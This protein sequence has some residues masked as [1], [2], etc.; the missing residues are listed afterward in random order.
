MYLINVIMADM[1]YVFEYFGLM[2]HHTIQFAFVFIPTVLLHRARKI[3]FG[4]Q[5]KDLKKGTKYL[6]YICAF[7]LLVSLMQALKGAHMIPSTDYIIFQLCFSG[8]GEEI[9]YR[10]IPIALLC[11]ASA[12]ETRIHLYGKINIDYSVLISALF[13]SIAHISFQFGSTNITYSWVQLLYSFSVGLILGHAY[14]KVN[15][16]WYCMFLHGLC[17]VVAIIFPL[18]FSVI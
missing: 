17:N 6:W 9:V 14:K 11:K 5:I 18:I 10:A 2:I 15:S 1:P 13:F 7:S 3:D 16:I 12:K 4:Y 8:L